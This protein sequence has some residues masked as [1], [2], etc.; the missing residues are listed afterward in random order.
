[1][2]TLLDAKGLNCPMPIVKAK[3][4]LK[5]LPAG[6]TLEVLATDPASAMDFQSFCKA[7]GN[8]LLE[9]GMDEGVYRYLIE[10]V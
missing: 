2:P 9:S 10:K 8:K 4:A 7:T 3:K 1:M 6:E 5:D